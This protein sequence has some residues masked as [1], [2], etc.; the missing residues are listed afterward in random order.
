M[1]IWLKSIGDLRDYFG[2]EPQEIDLN[3]KATLK[4]LL[5]IIGERWGEELPGY[6]WNKKELRFRGSVFFIINE[7]VVQDMRTHL[8]DKSQVTLFKAISGG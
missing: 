1:K 8:Q 2:R 5:L 3:E 7:E 4:D 6:L